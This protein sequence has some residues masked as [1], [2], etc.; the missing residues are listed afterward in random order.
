[1]YYICCSIY[2]C[3]SHKYYAN[4]RSALE[5]GYSLHYSWLFEWI[6][7]DMP[8]E[9]CKE[10]LAILEMYRAIAFSYFRLNDT[11]QLTDS[12]YQFPGF[13]GN[14]EGRQYGYCSY[15]ITELGRYQELLYGNEFYDLN[16]HCPML[17]KYKRMLE[18][19]DGYGS[20][21]AKMNLSQEQ[22]EELLEA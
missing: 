22:I 6:D 18:I 20:I 12:K 7:D 14:N 19:W 9:D 21:E 5:A 16:S 3:N 1:M 17:P 13:D 8:A 11:K 15:F 4:K 2:I 10:V